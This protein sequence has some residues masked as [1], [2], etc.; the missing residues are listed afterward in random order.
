MGKVWL[1]LVLTRLPELEHIYL[2]VRPKEGL[3]VEERF[4]EKVLTTEVFQPLRD[5]HGANFDEFIRSKV[6]PIAGDVA[7]PF[8]GLSNSLRLAIRSRIDA[9]VNVAGIVDFDPPL[10]DAL[11]VNAFGCRNLVELARDLG[12]SGRSVPLLHTS[13]CFTAGSRTG[14]IQELDPR[15]IP[16]PKAGQLPISSWDP[17]REIGECQVAVE[18]TRREVTAGFDRALL[19]ERARDHLGSP[20]AEPT[21]ED[22][23]REVARLEQKEMTAAL[24]ALG[25]E[26]ARR[27]GW[28]N[29]Y[30]YSKSMG[31]QVIAQSGVPFCIV[32][33]AIVESTLAFPFPGWNEGINTSAPFIFLI[34]QGGL[35]VPGSS[36]NLDLIPC[37]LVCTAL[38]LALGELIEG[39]QKPVYQAASSD[40]NPCTMARFFELSGLHKRRL[41]QRSGRTGRLVSKLQT[42][43]ESAL[44]TKDEYEAY[45]PRKLARGAESMSGFLFKLGRG[46]LAPLLKPAAR[47]LEGFAA[48]QKRLARVMDIFLPFVAEYHY[49]FRTDAVRAAFSRLVDAEKELF[50]WRPEDIDWRQWFLE[51]HAPALERHVF[52][53]ME[54]RMQ[55]RPRPARARG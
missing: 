2:V 29:T 25:M 42:H 26:R 21:E 20:G 9:I 53:E 5:A 3:G 40:T 4:A 11:R 51:I 38:T 15:E 14:H 27:W 16:F 30:T 46:P 18:E 28:P 54:R 49:V 32:R 55:K 36:N 37:D 10:D 7:E 22:V 13:T 6:T 52:P 23:A 45:G 33:P 43:Y 8:C 1:A 17:D 47:G 48:Q 31:E 12:V 44:L 41:Y 50:P 34:R 35:Q 39:R 19:S 24:S